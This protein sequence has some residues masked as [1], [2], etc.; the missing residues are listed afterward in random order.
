MDNINKEK[1]LKKKGWSTWYNPNYWVNPKMIV[2]PESQDYT[3]YGMSLGDAY[4]WESNRLGKVK[5][6]CGFPRMN[7]EFHITGKS[8][9]VK[10]KIKKLTKQD[11]KI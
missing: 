1:Y 10:N 4:V 11:K 6:I 8:T 2:D 9:K 7:M 3:D 5:S